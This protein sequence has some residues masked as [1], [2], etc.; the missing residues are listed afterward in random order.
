MAGFAVLTVSQLNQYIKSLLE[1]EPK[2]E[3]V[4]LRGEISNFTRHFSSGHMYFTLKDGVSAVKAVMF[5]S[6]ADYL[7]FLPENGMSVVVQGRVS[8]YPRD[9]VYQI[10]VNDMQPDGVG[11]LALAYEKLKRRLEGEGLFDAA[12]KKPIPEFPSR[13]GVITSR[14]GAVIQ[15][16]CNVL[17][18]RF[19]AVEAV[20]YPAQVQGASAPEQLVRAI[21]RADADG[22]CD[23]LIIA[24]GG[25]S[26]EDLWCFN[27]EGLA[28][29]IYACKTPVI[30]AVGHETDFTIADFVADL[31]APTPTAAAELAVPDAGELRYRIAML[32][33]SAGSAVTAR[34]K[35]LRE[36]LA[37]FR[38]DRL[39]ALAGEKAS[40]ARGRL[41]G[42]ISLLESEKRRRFFRERERLRTYV[43]LMDGASPMKILSRG[44]AAVSS[45]GAGVKSVGALLP[46]DRV[47]L[48]FADGAAEADII[49]TMYDTEGGNG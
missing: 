14:T 29:A 26:L 42:Y 11:A 31:R 46:G 27:D 20:L 38:G 28:R 18:R 6:A 25:G 44:F 41:N 13:I 39:A 10:Y 4:Y 30:S 1:A 9:G 22:G 47:R 43:L 3:S 16:I 7:R 34:I 49:E 19:P 48:R 45:G 35:A 37:F 17:T 15:D 5:K 2:L 8:V 33:A 36:R 12:G 21:K 23:V 24:R 40:A 32:G